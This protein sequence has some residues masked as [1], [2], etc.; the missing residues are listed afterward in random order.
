MD[1]LWRR[2]E[3]IDISIPDKF[4]EQSYGPEKNIPAPSA[5]DDAIIW[6]TIGGLL[7]ILSVLFAFLCL[8]KLK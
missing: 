3:A 2:I 8:K 7:L 6:G 4:L 5:N 1:D